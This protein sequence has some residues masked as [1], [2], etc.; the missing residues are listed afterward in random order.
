MS[1]SAKEKSVR[2]FS[3]GWYN[4]KTGDR[5]VVLSTG[6]HFTINEKQRDSSSLVSTSRIES[7]LDRDENVLTYV[8]DA[9]EVSR[10][11]TILMEYYRGLYLS[12]GIAI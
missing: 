7:E 2:P 4:H 1:K 12:L 6:I 10:I 3:R 11:R 8:P 9:E 5:T